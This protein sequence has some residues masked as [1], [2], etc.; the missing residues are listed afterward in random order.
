PDGKHVF[1][2]DYHGI[3]RRWNLETKQA[4]SDLKSTRSA[5][6]SLNFSDGGKTLVSTC[7]DG[8]IRRWD[9]AGGKEIDPPQGYLGPLYAHVS[10][11]GKS[12]L[13]LDH[14]GRIDIWDLKSKTIRTKVSPAGSIE[15]NTSLV[16][17][18]FGFTGDGKQVFLILE[19][20]KVLL[21]NANS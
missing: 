5:I 9:L 6:T 17:P 8:A 14:T 21:W 12:V 18:M 15:I 10:P 7:Y 19:F 3:I 16:E 20:G 13:L 1:A 11:D 4:E 2:G